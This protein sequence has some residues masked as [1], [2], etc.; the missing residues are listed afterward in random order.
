MWLGGAAFVLSLAFAARFYIVTLGR[1]APARGSPTAALATDAALFGL[2]ALH[3]SLAAR[4]GAQR[5]LARVVAERLLR[6][7]YVWLASALLALVC[8][9]WRPVGGSLYDHG[10]ALGAAHLAVQLAGVWLTLRSVRAIDPLEL[11]GIRPAST[12]SALQITGPYRFVRHPI[13]VA[14]VLMT[15][16][17]AH[18]TGDRLAFAAISTA[19]LIVAIPWEERSL[20][21]AF[22]EAYVDYRRRVRW[23]M[24]PHVY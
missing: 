1:A 5:A 16:G 17:A 7:A 14:W 11:A 19:Y 13:Y 9:A 2:F 23:R 22:G 4:P 10:G 21:R 24:V 20:V 12:A 3:H 18:M 8:V 6:S 15:F